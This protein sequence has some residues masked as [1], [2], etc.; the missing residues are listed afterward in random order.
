MKD[1]LNIKNEQGEEKEYDILL[2][3]E[4]NKQEYIV[5]TDYSHDENNNIKCYSC[6]YTDNKINEIKDP[7]VIK[8]IDNMLNTLTETTRLKYQRINN[9]KGE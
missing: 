8:T 7:E 1:K 6:E 4:I 5:Y 9:R 3:F 2:S